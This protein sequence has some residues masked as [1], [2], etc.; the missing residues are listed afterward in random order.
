MAEIGNPL[1]SIRS[2]EPTLRH[3]HDRK[4]RPPIFGVGKMLVLQLSGTAAF[5]TVAECTSV[6]A[7]GAFV[8]I[9]EDRILY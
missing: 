4:S 7:V 8:I 5:G 9:R 2:T 6:I 1:C 3:T